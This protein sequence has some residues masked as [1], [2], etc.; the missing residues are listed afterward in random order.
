MSQKSDF[1][2]FVFEW[3]FYP[4]AVF[5]NKH[6]LI[7]LPLWNLRV[8]FRYHG[9]KYSLFP[10][11]QSQSRMIKYWVY[12]DPQLYNISA[13]SL[14]MEIFIFKAYRE[15]IV[16]LTWHSCMLAATSFC[17]CVSGQGTDFVRWRLGFRGSFTVHAK[18]F[19]AIFTFPFTLALSPPSSL[20]SF[21]YRTVLSSLFLKC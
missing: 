7:S 3:Y 4:C 14:G 15:V 13:A 2:V 18:A 16:I 9:C 20:H 5:Q 19:H 1:Y 8:C 12:K 11:K 17:G 10:P 6:T 21:A